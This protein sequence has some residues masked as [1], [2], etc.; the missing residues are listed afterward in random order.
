[1]SDRR[2]ISINCSSSKQQFAFQKSPRF[3]GPKA[4]TKA[5]GYEL[6]PYFGIKNGTN[7]GKGFNSSTK[8]F[9][10]PRNNSTIKIDGPGDNDNKGNAFSKTQQYSFGVSRHQMK[11]VYVDEI[12]NTRKNGEPGPA[13]YEKEPLFGNDAKT[14]AARYSM[15]PKN[16]LFVNHLDKQKKLPGPGFYHDS[17]NMAGK[18]PAS[19]LQHQQPQNAFSKAHDRFRVTTFNTP[20]PASYKPKTDL[21]ENF[22]SQHKYYGATKFPGDKRTFM[23]TLW[24][25][26][27]QQKLPAPTS[28]QSFSEFSG[29]PTK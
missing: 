2:A 24:N 4:Y 5:F 3:N 29:L 12:L 11:K 6:E 13:N 19:S 14:A 20:A 8:R 10:A 1:M 26:K 21:N 9:I 18:Q 16:D 15:R 7:T 23:D 27:E 28:Y 25:P 22:N 17:V